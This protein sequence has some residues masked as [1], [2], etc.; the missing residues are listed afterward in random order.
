[1]EMERYR[2]GERVIE[3]ERER[4]GDAVEAAVGAA[5]GA[6]GHQRAAY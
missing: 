1:M 6:G 3:R 5:V 2:G 4:D